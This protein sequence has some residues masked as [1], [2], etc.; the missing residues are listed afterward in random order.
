MS[1]DALAQ[2]RKVNPTL[3]IKDIGDPAFERYGRN[4]PQYD[5]SEMITRTRAIVPETDRVAYETSVEALEEPSAL[6]TALIQEVFGGMDTQIGWCY[7][8]NS[9]LNGLEYHR[10]SEV[11]VCITDTVFLVAHVQDVEFGDEIRFD[12]AK[13]EAFFAPEGSVVEF[14]PWNMHLAPI[15]VRS[16]EPFCTLVYL[17]RGTNERLPFDVPQTGE[18]RLL[19]AVNKWLMGHPSLERMIQG[20]VYPG[21]V[22]DNIVVNPI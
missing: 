18:N 11:N 14:A 22:G 16:G 12:T 20:G 7:G 17:P 19:R 6:N 8:Q 1:N 5:A 13:V 9:A 15:N 10:G 3:D 2:L 4:L 21:L